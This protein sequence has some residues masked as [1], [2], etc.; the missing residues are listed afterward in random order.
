MGKTTIGWT[1]RSANPIR[2][3]HK[4][5]GRV[6][7]HC[8]MCSPG[9]ANCYSWRRN[10]R[11]GTKLAYNKRSEGEIDLFLD[12]RPMEAIARL[13]VPHQ[14]V[15]VCDMTDLFADF[16]P[17]EWIDRIF[18]AMTAAPDQTF[19][20]LTK[21]PARMAAYL[22]GRPAGP[23]PNCWLGTSVEDQVRAEERIPALVRVTAAAVRFLSVEPILED[24]RLPLDGIE[25]VIVGGE[26]G[27]GWRACDVGWIESVVGQ[28]REAG[29]PAFVKQDSALRPG[30]QG[31][32]SD[33]LWAVKDFPEPNGRLT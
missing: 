21:R 17:D 29:V 14:M 7:W 10:G 13:K 6:G 27:P 24:I 12:L 11:F 16:V 9:C 32:L 18:D 20:V 30:R 28:C 33:A 3:R 26:S 19:Q 25:W 1:N 4:G 15:F 5:T 22:E 31:R 23:P 2:A 8:V